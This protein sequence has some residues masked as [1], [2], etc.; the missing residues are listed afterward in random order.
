MPY[1]FLKNKTPLCEAS[2][3]KIS[4]RVLMQ[5][6]VNSIKLTLDG[7]NVVFSMCTCLHMKTMVMICI[8]VVIIIDLGQRQKSA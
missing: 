8:K 1:F 2:A 6:T 4:S 5:L 7:I 3:C